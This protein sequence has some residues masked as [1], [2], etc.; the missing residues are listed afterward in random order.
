MNN[1][2]TIAKR[3]L[4]YFINTPVAYIVTVAFLV[5]SFFLYWRQTLISNDASL[6]SFFSLLPWFLLLVIPALTM[7]ALA[8]ERRKNTVELLLAHPIK[9]GEIVIGKFLGVWCFYLIILGL[10]LSL[11]ITLMKWANPDVSVI[12]GQYIGAIFLGAAMTAMGILVSTWLSQAITVFLASAGIGFGWILLG[13]DIVNLA[14]PWPI[15]RIAHELA[16]L[17]HADQLARG[18]I[19]LRDVSYFITVTA[20]LLVLSAIK[21]SENKLIE[22]L[23]KRSRLYAGAIIIAGIGIVI[24]LIL[25]SWPLR[26]DLTSDKRFTLSEGT[27]STLT[28]IPDIVSMTFYASREL[29]AQVQII[30]RDVEDLLKDYS[31]FGSGKVKFSVLNPDTD[32]DIAK[33]A[34][35]AGVQQIQFNT[36]ASGK[37]SVEAGFLGLVIRYGDNQ[38]VIPYVQDVGDLEYNLTQKIRKLTIKEQKTIGFLTGQEEKSL[39]QDMTVWSEMLNDQYKTDTVTLANPTD[40]IR[41]DVLVIAGPSTS[42]AEAT[43]SAKVKDFVANNGKVLWLLDGV[44]A[45]TQ[46]GI[47]N[48]VDHG[49]DQLL[50][51]YGLLL[52]KN[53]AYDVQL[54]ENIRIGQGLVQV[55]TPYPFWVRSLPTEEGKSLMQIPE[56]VLMA[57][58]SEVEVKNGQ[59]GVKLTKLLTT[60]K[61]GGKVEGT[62]SISPDTAPKQGSGQPVLLAVAAEKDGSRIVLVGDSELATDNFMQNNQANQLFLSNVIDWLVADKTLAQVPRRIIV[63]AILKFNSPQD[64]MFAQYGNIIG[65]PI[66]VAIFGFWWLRRRNNLTKRDYTC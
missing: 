34:G 59:E 65:L 14:L 15:N 37:F 41:V 4:A 6:R 8:E 22:N 35:Q 48:P 42:V 30:K 10:T 53:M 12:I 44:Q 25:T 19:E 39:F 49:W 63:P 27:K 55:I 11:P 66:L 16:L 46:L 9:G 32:P 36:I 26:L 47:A 54:N 3:E 45:N 31:R 50:A 20:V 24:N 64:A 61:A 40:E 52:K 58:S 51:D 43:A 5:P 1:I 13:L 29:P 17:P 7:R 23:S 33:Q 62:L 21:L 56:G 57:W 2:F 18:L 60:S 28:N 38:E